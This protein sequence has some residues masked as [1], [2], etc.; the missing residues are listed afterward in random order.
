MN[1]FTIRPT[2]KQEEIFLYA[3]SMQLKN[4]TGFIGHLRG[5]FGR[6]GDE[7][8]T[9]WFDFRED[10]KTEDFKKRFDNL[11]NALR[12][13]GGALA[14][15][16]TMQAHAAAQGTPLDLSMYPP[17]YGFRADTGDFTCMLR[18]NGQAGDYNFYIWSYRRDWLDGY[19]KDAANGIRFITP[20]YK[21]LFILPNNG[22]VVF[23]HPDGTKNIERCRYID[24]YHVEVGTNGVLYHICELAERL[25]EAGITCEPKQSE[26]TEA[27]EVNHE[28]A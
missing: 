4:T 7:F 27:Q 5:D 24:A 16:K 10:L 9:T 28:N 15:L 1:N 17:Q 18:L 8:W 23:S 19:L 13:P 11:I 12:Q 25:E 2:E 6:D 20:H 26:T 22:E 3:L 14:D 21:N